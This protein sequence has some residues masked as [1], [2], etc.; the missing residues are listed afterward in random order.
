VRYLAAGIGKVHIGSCR[1]VGSTSLQFLCDSNESVTLKTFGYDSL[2]PHGYTNSFRDNIFVLL[3][4]DVE[5]RWKSGTITDCPY[6]AEEYVNYTYTRWG[7]Q[8]H[9]VGKLD[10][11]GA[12]WLDD[13]FLSDIVKHH[14]VTSDLSWMWNDLHTKFWEWNAPQHNTEPLGIS[15]LEFSKFENIYFLELKDL[16]NPK[17]L[18]WLQER[19]SEW[20]CIE[21]IPHKNPSANIVEP[22]MQKKFKEGYGNFWNLY[23]NGKILKDKVLVNPFFDLPGNDLVDEFKHKINLV[24]NEQLMVDDIREN[25]KNYIR[26]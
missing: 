3:L 20:E 1:K 7:E 21:E 18:K 26:F 25:H 5:E 22:D 17:F 15:L 6:P 8:K 16:S 2:S 24:K 13:D 23:Q 11:D 14:S 9:Y 10:E 19:D 4:R 12:V